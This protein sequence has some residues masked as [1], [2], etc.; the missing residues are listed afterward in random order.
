MKL[1]VQMI[2]P[3][4]AGLVVIL[5]VLLCSCSE[6]PNGVIQAPEIQR[7]NPTTEGI[8]WFEGSIEEA[9]ASMRSSMP[10]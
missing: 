4:A 8:P 5:I 3:L 1:E 6:D 2:K 10:E 7:D 9:F